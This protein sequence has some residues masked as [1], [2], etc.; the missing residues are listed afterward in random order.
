MLVNIQFEKVNLKHQKDIFEWLKEPHMQEF[1][2]NSQGHKDDILNF[3]NGRTE[4][5]NY[6]KGM[7]SYWVG[8]IDGKPYSLIMTHAENESTN[9][10]GYMKPYLS[11]SGKTFGLD[12]CIGNKNF[13]GQGLGA[14][15]LIAFMEYFS[16]VIEPEVDT[17]LIDPFTNNPRAIHVYQKAGFQV[18]CE[19]TQEGGYFNQ[20]KGVLMVKKL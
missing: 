16:S 6:F 2:D 10:P 7:N 20:H 11:N 9:P 18:M 3:M 1:W 5:S 12:F 8:S 14:S 17:F 19:F 15:T 4:P 13:F